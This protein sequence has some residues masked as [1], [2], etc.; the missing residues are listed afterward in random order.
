M[1]YTIFISGVHSG[2]NPSPGV[3]IARSL[4]KVFPEA[5]LVAVDYSRRSSGLL[6]DC[7][8]SCWIQPSWKGLDLNKYAAEIRSVLIARNGFWISGLDLETLWLSGTLPGHPKILCP[9]SASLAKTA[10]PAP[11]VSEIMGL[12]TPPWISLQNDEAD[13]HS[14]CRNMGWQ[15]WVKGPW[16]EAVRAHNWTGV[17]SAYHRINETWKCGESAFIQQHVFGVETSIA[18]VSYEGRLLSCVYMSKL[19]IT[20]EGKTWSGK[21]SAVPIELKD[22]LSILVKKLDYT[23]GG[24]I[25]MVR[26]NNGVL[27]LMELNPRFP[28]W[29]YGATIAGCNMPEQ[30]IR[31]ASEIPFSTQYEVFPCDFTRIILEIPCKAF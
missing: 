2:P 17:I 24:E 7:F 11:N 14:F 8:D 9:S 1:P 19:E 18:F 4:R 23:G 25:E 16:Y 15:V 29:I 22:R 13:I 31:A 27:W 3:G 5:R 10:K 6:F 21:V 28:A 12:R 20:A 26:D 30:L